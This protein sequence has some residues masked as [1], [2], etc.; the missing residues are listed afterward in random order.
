MQQLLQHSTINT[1]LTF[2]NKTA[3]QYA[4]PSERAILSFCLYIYITLA[5]LLYFTAYDRRSTASM[6]C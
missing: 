4:Q 2:E 1:T 3:L 5:H 6:D